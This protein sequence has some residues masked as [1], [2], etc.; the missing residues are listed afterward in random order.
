M[1]NR[2]FGRNVGTFGKNRGAETQR[3]GCHESGQ[4]AFPVTGFSL[5]P[6]RRRTIPG[7]LSSIHMYLPVCYKKR[8]SAYKPLQAFREMMITFTADL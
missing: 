6:A 8:I 4:P 5:V 3:K 1:N 2:V 7:R